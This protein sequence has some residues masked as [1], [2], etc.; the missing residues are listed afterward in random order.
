MGR[1]ERQIVF[2]NKMGGIDMKK[3]KKEMYVIVVHEKE[4]RSHYTVDYLYKNAD[5]AIIERDRF[6]E[7]TGIDKKKTEIIKIEVSI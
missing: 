7:Q 2:C 1:R 6:C 4:E 5:T 3:E